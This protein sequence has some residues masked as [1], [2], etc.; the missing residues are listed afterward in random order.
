MEALSRQES[1]NGLRVFFVMPR[2]SKATV[3][4]FL[5]KEGLHIPVLLDKTGKISR[6]FGVWVQPTTYLIDRHGMIRYRVMGA[7]D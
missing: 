1:S 6:L 2:E 7:V 4:K 3:E 5:E